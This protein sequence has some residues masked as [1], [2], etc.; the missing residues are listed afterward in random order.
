[1]K[2]P[3]SSFNAITPLILFVILFLFSSLMWG[4]T[5]SPLFPC[6]L[7]IIYSL[8]C[9]FKKEISFN[10]RIELFITG[11]S[12][13]TAIATCYILFF[14]AIFSYVLNLIGSTH[15][16]VHASL[17]A[18]PAHLLLPGFFSLVSF[19]AIAIGSSMGA[20][21]AFIPIGLGIGSTLKADP[22]LMCGIV[23]GGAMLGDNLSIISDTTIA[24]TQTTGCKM[25]DKFKANFLMV[26]PAFIGTLIIL[27]YLN[28]SLA[29]SNVI[30]TQGHALSWEQIIPICPYLLVF[31]LAP[32][33]IDVLALLVGGIFLGT[34][35]GIWQGT[36]T[37]LQSTALLID[38]FAQNTSIQEVL[39][40]VLFVAGLSYLVEYNGGIQY[41]IDHLSR[42]IKSR[43]AA[44]MSISL[45]VFLV[46]MAVAINTIAIL[47]TGPVAKRIADQFNIEKKRVASL[48]DIVA[49]I[50]QGILPYSA[51]LLLA[52]SL[53]K[54]SSISIMPYLHYQWLMALVTFG[55]IGHTYITEKKHN[56]SL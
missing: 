31:L 29:L 1:M 17:T 15:I 43:A 40:L 5:I 26:I 42:K 12:Q 50:C 7:A 51:Q 16:A 46:N 56:T 55:S 32:L 27:F 44:E 11:S 38:G 8:L 37:F 3:D 2:T 39:I 9:T 24:A 22:A 49:C 23:V 4:Q 14:S 28:S 36:F 6:L 54:I 47:V 34:A 53:A 19:F 18:I 33:N 41:L 30:S 35:I 48:I 45:L 25:S 10:K 20:I 52:A 13:Q 21:A